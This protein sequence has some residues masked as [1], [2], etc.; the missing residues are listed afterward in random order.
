MRFQPVLVFAF[1][2]AAPTGCG[3]SQPRAA[4]NL[5][6]EEKIDV[7]SRKVDE[8]N[9]LVADLKLAKPDADERYRSWLATNLTPGKTTLS[10]VKSI[11]G[12]NYMN[13]DRPTRDNVLTIQYPVADLAGRKLVL[14][15][16]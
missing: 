9:A 4:V 16:A 2:V 11:F 7:L 6:L 10:E 1:L 15:F 12:M 5:K 3:Q 13:L 14:D 8:L